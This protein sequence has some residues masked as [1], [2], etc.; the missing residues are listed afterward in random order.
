MK[1]DSMQG[2]YLY[3]LR[4]TLSAERKLAKALGKLVKGATDEALKQ[5]FMSHA[6]ETQTHAERL[7]S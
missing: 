4:D 2:L 5:A 3:E 1:I 7:E 6:E